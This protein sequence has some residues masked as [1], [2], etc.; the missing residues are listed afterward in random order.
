MVSAQKVMSMA[1]TAGTIV[2]RNPGYMLETLE[3]S[4]AASMLLT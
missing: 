1:V 2:R 4:G 3:L